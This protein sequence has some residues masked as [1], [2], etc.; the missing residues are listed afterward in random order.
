MQNNYLTLFD[1]E[2]KIWRVHAHETQPLL[3]VETR[4]ELAREVRFSMLNMSTNEVLWNQL[5]L[6]DDWWR[7]FETMNDEVLVLHGFEDAGNPVRAG[8][9][10]YDL[11]SGSKLYSNDSAVFNQLELDHVVESVTN[12]EQEQYYRVDLANNG[13]TLLDDFKSDR[14]FH[15]TQVL[16][17]TLVESSD[18]SFPKIFNFI[19]RYDT[20]PN[21]IICVEYLEWQDH[22]CVAYTSGVE[23]KLDL[24]LMIVDDHGHMLLSEMLSQGVRGI[25]LGSFLV[26][27]GYLVFV[28]NAVGIG[29]YSIGQKVVK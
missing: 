3:L 27:Q 11:R 5:D 13:K 15:S 2:T 4:D 6:G 28:K 7:A 29:Y 14:S 16:N 22:I 10:V 19:R 25:T 20:N 1:F 26:T 9:Y 21:T 23:G 12:G 18:G 24:K 8:V 17:P